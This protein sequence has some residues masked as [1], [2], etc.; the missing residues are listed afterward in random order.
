MVL[1]AVCARGY[2]SQV[3]A[4]SKFWDNSIKNVESK[5]SKFSKFLTTARVPSQKGCLD[6]WGCFGKLWEGGP[7]GNAGNPSNWL[8]VRPPRPRRHSK[9]GPAGTIYMEISSSG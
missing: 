3:Y 7:V 9:G 6:L 8:H 4:C 1:S 5:F 2:A